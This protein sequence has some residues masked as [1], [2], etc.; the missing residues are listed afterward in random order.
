MC[1]RV[2]V[3]VCAALMQYVALWC[4]LRV[5]GMKTETRKGCFSSEGSWQGND[6][7]HTGVTVFWPE[8]E[9]AGALT[10]T[11]SQREVQTRREA[12]NKQPG[13]SSNWRLST[14]KAP[15]HC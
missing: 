4:G 9:L 8:L 14:V 11:V 15:G 7:M 1:L 3:Y 10:L 6:L 13:L 5:L 12:V 2:C